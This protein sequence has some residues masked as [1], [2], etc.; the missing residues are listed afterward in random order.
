MA[1]GKKKSNVLEAVIEAVIAQIKPGEAERKEAEKELNVFSA[2]LKKQVK[3]ATITVGGSF[4]KGTWLKGM[5]DLDVFVC[6][7][8]RKYSGKSNVIADCLQKALKK[9]G[10]RYKRLHGSRD[11]FQARKGGYN[12]E[13][14]PILSIK[15]SA[16]AKNITD[17]SPLHAKWVNRKINAK[18]ADQVR[19]L[20][21]FC[22]AQGFYGAETHIKGFSGYV[23]EILVANY[24]SFPAVL[25]AALKWNDKEAV[26]VERHYK[27]RNLM[28]E[29][30]ASKTQSPL[31]V[32]DP[33]QPDRNAAAALSSDSLGRFIK[34]AGQFLKKPS[35]EFFAEK[36]TTLE[37]LKRKAKGKKL[38]AI[39]AT[40]L[41]GKH[42]VVCTKILKIEEHIRKQLTENGFK[43]LASGTEWNDKALVWIMADGKKLASHKVISGPPLSVEKHV[44]RFRKKHKKMF[45]RNGKA[46]AR[47]RRKYTEAMQLARQL[48]KD[49]Y[50]KE[51]AEKV[52]LND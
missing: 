8:Y 15:K 22:K 38:I 14:I 23:C 11:Y 3:G 7:D 31:I 36:H 26:D 43:V 1:A 24:G 50:V 16:Q 28:A 27:G 25:R 13:L 5:H 34:A 9:S 46:Y 4:A 45:A 10:L 19:L 21:A 48:L 32:V 35:H 40:P 6:F 52:A 29:M 33:V 41:K 49:P 18:Q 39:T 20:K 12:F 51:K 47:V 17:V 42:D 37:E 30:N 44:E 2:S